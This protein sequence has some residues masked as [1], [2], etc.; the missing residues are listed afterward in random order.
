M[1]AKARRGDWS[2]TAPAGTVGEAGERSDM[3]E[4]CPSPRLGATGSGPHGVPLSTEDAEV[5]LVN[6]ECTHYQ[7]NADLAR[8]KGE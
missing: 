3:P 8:I 2:K 6:F 5:L 4:G 7:H 1:A